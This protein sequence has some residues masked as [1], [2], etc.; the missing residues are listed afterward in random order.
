MNKIEQVLE[1][2]RPFCDKVSKTSEEIL[3]K[4]KSDIAP[5][6]LIGLNKLVESV[7]G[8]FSPT[9]FIFNIPL[10][11]Q[12]H[13]IVHEDELADLPLDAL[14]P[15]PNPRLSYDSLSFDELHADIKENGMKQRI[16][17]RPSATLKG[18]Y[19]ILDG[20]RRKKVVERLGWAT[21]KVVIK[22]IGDIE[23]HE[24]AFASNNN[25]SELTDFEKG[26]W[27]KKMLAEFPD[28]YPNQ[29]VIAKRF[30]TSQGMVSRLITYYEEQNKELKVPENSEV[31]PRGIAL[32][33][34][35]SEHVVREIRSASPELQP[36]LRAA[37]VER[38]L[39]REEVHRLK[40]V[41]ET[42][43]K[44][45]EEALKEQQEEYASQERTEESKKRS[46]VNALKE[47]YPENVLLLVLE[48]FGRQ[49]QEKTIKATLVFVDKMAQKV[50]ELGL[51]EM[52]LTE[53]EKELN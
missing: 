37:A 26:R 1:E 14:V 19:E 50:A 53:T 32:K 7:G 21:V 48:R 28:Q 13:Q 9:A 11:K 38:N 3:L 25:R 10:P 47:Y 23:A 44:P 18:K 49:S 4:P 42:S 20:N 31:M 29:G 22:Y 51:T 6:R 16:I 24:Y 36:A 43:N 52:L 41:L 12:P 35:P 46:L 2:M 17:V 39:G 8:T 45:I 30:G 40:V 34:L 33:G 27:F 15:G 5:A